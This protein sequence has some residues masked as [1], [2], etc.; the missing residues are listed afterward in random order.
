MKTDIG[1]R[2]MVYGGI[3]SS[4][5]AILALLAFMGAE[6]LIPATQGDVIILA[7]GVKENKAGL[8]IIQ[9]SANQDQLWQTQ[10]RMEQ[11]QQRGQ[12]VEDLQYRE[13][14]L[15]KEQQRLKRELQKVTQ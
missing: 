4:V 7:G 5:L 12:P 15:R 10:D 2:I 1:K 8:L 6:K 13:R 14:L 9:Q 11:L 3:A